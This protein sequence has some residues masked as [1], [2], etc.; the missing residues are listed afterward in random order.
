[1]GTK[2]KGGENLAN[3]S[4]TRD[5]PRRGPPTRGDGG[6]LISR[7]GSKIFELRSVESSHLLCIH[8][9]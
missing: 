4:E 5:L 6:F 1:M 8:N 3:N 2:G 9:H 7:L